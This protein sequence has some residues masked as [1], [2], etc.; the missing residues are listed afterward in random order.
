MKKEYDEFIKILIDDKVYRNMP[1]NC[2]SAYIYYKM[3]I[4]KK[5]IDLHNK[6]NKFSSI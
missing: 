4:L 5:I 3:R 2:Q 1:K 6:D